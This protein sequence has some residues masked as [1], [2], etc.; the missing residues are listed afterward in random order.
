MTAK[1]QEIVGMDYVVSMST[2]NWVG[3]HNLKVMPLGDFEMI[4][5]IDF[6]RKF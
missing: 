3:K 4:L 2:G 5:D 6:L 1:A